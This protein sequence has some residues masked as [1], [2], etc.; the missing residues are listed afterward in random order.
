M[1]IIQE[2]F[3]IPSELYQG[4]MTGEY[5]RDGGVIRV[6]DGPSRGQI[7]K[8]LDPIEDVDE[9][10]NGVV[11]GS[12]NI[13]KNYVIIAGATL[14]VLVGG[15]AI[16]KAVKNYEPK[17]VKVF[18]ERIGDYLTAIKK[19]TVDF[20]VVDQLSKALE[21]LRKIKNYEKYKFNFTAEEMSLFI[22]YMQSYTQ[23]LIYDN[24]FECTDNDTELLCSTGE[25]LS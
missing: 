25:F 20:L 16:Y 14:V 24:S 18:R 12:L 21:D 19:G 17:E 23:K 15:F 1:A 13:D 22:G 9:S 5:Y 11:G 7:V 2:T 8:M 3:E 4:L 10:L 6:G